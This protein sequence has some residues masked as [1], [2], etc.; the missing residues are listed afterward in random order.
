MQVRLEY[1]TPLSICSNSIRTC[2]DSFNN[3]GNY[4]CHTDVITDSDKNLMERVIKKNNHSSTVEH[5]VYHFDVRDISRDLLQ[6]W[7]RHRHLSQSVKST[8]YTLKELKSAKQEELYKFLKS[9]NK[10]IDSFNIRQLINVQWFLNNRDYTNDMLK[11]MLP[12]AYL[13][14]LKATINSR[15]LINMLTLRSNSGALLEF[16]ELSKMIYEQIPEAHK[17]LYDDIFEGTRQ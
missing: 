4:E 5:I 15:S 14:Q 7:S 2:W 16:Q 9:V 8:R 11:Y 3:G 6:E 13:T 17:F 1:Y 10:E 12:G